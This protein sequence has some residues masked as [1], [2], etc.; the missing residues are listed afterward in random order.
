LPTAFGFTALKAFVDLTALR[1]ISGD[2]SL[3][4]FS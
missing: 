3:G 1:L 4:T 2:A